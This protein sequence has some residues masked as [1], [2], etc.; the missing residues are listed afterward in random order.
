MA[1][2]TINI[3]VNDGKSNRE[4]I[5]KAY[6]AA[7]TVVNRLFFLQDTFRELSNPNIDKIEF[8]SYALFGF[9]EILE[10]MVNKAMDVTEILRDVQG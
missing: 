8:S 7:E 5:N 2:T 1:G 3:N 4:E 10:D 6:E 9:Y